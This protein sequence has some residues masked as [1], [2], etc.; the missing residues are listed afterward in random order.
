MPM[1]KTDKIWMNGQFVAWDEAKVHVLAHVLHYGSSVF[2]GIRAYQTKSGTAIFRLEDHIERLFFSAKVYRMKIPFTREQVE[3]ACIETVAVNRLNECYIRPLVYRGYEN[4]GVNPIGVPID[5]AIAAYP[6]GKYLGDEAL[7]KGVSVKVGTWA[8]MAANTLPA[9]A[10]AGGNYLNSQLLRLEAADDGYAEAIALDPH[11]YIS[12]GSGENLFVVHKGILYT[13]GVASSIL[14]G[15]TR[16]SVIKLAKELGYEVREQAMPRE[17]LY[18]ADEL[19]F[20]GT[21][22]EV[23]PITL[24]DKLVVGSGE[25][26]PVTKALQDAYFAAVRGE[27]PKHAAWLTNVPVAATAPRS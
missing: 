10:K 2:E 8:R 14:M 24:V 9:M 16:D 1:T 13:P 4:I 11:G 22:V 20:V 6:W 15:I 7:A 27:N 26:G 17:M 12:E 23:T 3:R 19:F 5:V 25:R 21:A 18:A